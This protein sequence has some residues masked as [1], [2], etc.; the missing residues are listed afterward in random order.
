MNPV[1]GSRPRRPASNLAGVG[2]GE[3]RIE[4]DASHVP[5]PVGGRGS[6]RLAPPMRK[7]LAMELL[8]KLPDAA[9]ERIKEREKE[10]FVSEFPLAVVRT[11]LA[12]MA[13]R[14]VLLV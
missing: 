9:K 12:P 4:S 13:T 14:G 5:S 7:W 11:H 3:K 6:F 10:I 2:A 8:I 1:K